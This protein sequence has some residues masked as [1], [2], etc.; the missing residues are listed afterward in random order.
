LDG[1]VD[2]SIEAQVYDL[3][4]EVEQ[5]IIDEL[6]TR[7]VRVICYISVGSQEA[8][9]P[10]ADLFPPVVLGRKYEG[11]SGEKW[12]DI[13]RIDLLSPIMLARLDQCAAK[14][15]DGVEP[16][17]IEVVGNDT[18]FPLTYQDQLDYARWL[19][20]EAHTRGLAIG[21]KNAPDMVVDVLDYFD[22]VITEDAYYYGWIEDMLPFI[23]DGKPV[24][25]AEYTD[26]DV[27][28]DAACAWGDQHQVYF[29][30]K[31]RALTSHRQT[32]P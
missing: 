8:W 11:W 15:F 12:L 32:C 5:A 2:T 17:N 28:F 30:L 16:D 18:G 27:D 3:D 6:H 13:R 14:G 20:S 22:F 31:D 21:L 23:E 10:D 26:M 19:A 29:I 25:A 1:E 4:L 24:F 7:G 9:R